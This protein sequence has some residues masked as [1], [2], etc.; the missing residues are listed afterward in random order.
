MLRPHHLGLLSPAST[1]LLFETKLLH[2]HPSM[3]T[4][5][6]SLLQC[7]CSVQVC[8]HPDLFEGR[9][10]VSSFDMWGMNF[11]LPSLAMHALVPSKWGALNLSAINADLLAQEHD[12]IWAAQ[13]RQV[14]VTLCNVLSLC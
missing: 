4:P 12:S 8:N 13:T 3:Y 14:P 9:P 1:R 10:I 6:V 2:T 7:C 5:H 11:H